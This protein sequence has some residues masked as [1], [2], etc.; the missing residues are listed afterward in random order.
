MP[1]SLRA[2]VLGS[3]GMG[4]IALIL[5]QHASA[6][7]S[8]L[9]N[10]NEECPLRRTRIYQ[11]LTGPAKYLQTAATDLPTGSYLLKIRKPAAG[12][13]RVRNLQLGRPSGL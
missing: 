5:V 9:P 6:R 7:S 11:N 1:R 13:R 4:R 12:M 8:S 10:E 3:M 2:I